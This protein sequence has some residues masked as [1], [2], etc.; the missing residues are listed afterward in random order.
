MKYLLLFFTSSLV[1]ASFTVDKIKSMKL[2]GTEY[3]IQFASNN[4]VFRLSE[5]NPVIPC[6][7]NSVKAEQLVTIE[8]DRQAGEIRS[9]RLT[10]HR[11]PG[12]IPGKY[13]R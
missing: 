2:D 8:V 13:Q 12:S 7:E 5:K 9:C 3:E 11:L 10:P 4:Q 6:L 1:Q